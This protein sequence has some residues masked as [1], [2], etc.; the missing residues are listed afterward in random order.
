M[1]YSVGV[2]VAWEI[3]SYE[4]ANKES[5]TIEIDHIMLG[6]LS[7]N[8]FQKHIKLQANIDQEK[9]NSEK[10]RLYN[11]LNSFNL[12][13]IT[14]RRKL[15]DIL[16]KGNGLPLDNIFHRSEDCKKVFAEAACFANNHLSIKYLFLAI[17][18]RN[19]SYFRT[20]L[21]DQ[22]IDINKLKSKVMFSYYKNN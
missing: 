20:I 15:R 5:T 8:K 16:P 14:L 7:L 22:K 4:A 9:L 17:I 19:S 6:I 21:I 2:K 11:T 10:D 3:S 13:I 18:L 1:C 12:D